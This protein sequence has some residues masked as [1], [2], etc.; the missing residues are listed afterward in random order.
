MYTLKEKYINAFLYCVK[1]ADILN[2]GSF[3]SIGGGGVDD[4]W[5]DYLGIDL[6]NVFS[7][8][9]LNF[10]FQVLVYVFI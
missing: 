4:L 2:C 7:E 6:F 8:S 5:V 9:S 3:P 10:T 1:H